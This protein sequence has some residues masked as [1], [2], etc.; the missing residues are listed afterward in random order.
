M[1]FWASFALVVETPSI[2]M[3]LWKKNEKKSHEA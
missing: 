1:R 2:M 3:L